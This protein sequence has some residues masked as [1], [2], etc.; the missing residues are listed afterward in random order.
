MDIN[1]QL[2]GISRLQSL[3]ICLYSF[4]EEYCQAYVQIQSPKSKSQESKFKVSSFK[5]PGFGLWLMIKSEV[6]KNPPTPQL[7][8]QL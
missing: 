3:M 5:S 1:Y 2:S 7:K 6:A 4:D 8:I